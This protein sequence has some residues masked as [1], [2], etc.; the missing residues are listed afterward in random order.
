[1]Q[2]RACS[3]FSFFGDDKRESPSVMFFTHVSDKIGGS[4]IGRFV[5]LEHPLTA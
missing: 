2:T 4:V 1:M 5:F 3:D